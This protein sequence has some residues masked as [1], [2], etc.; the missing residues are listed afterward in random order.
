MYVVVFNDENR[1]PSGSQSSTEHTQAVMREHSSST[2]TGN[3]RS[4]L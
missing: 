1:P 3:I 4:L 2:A